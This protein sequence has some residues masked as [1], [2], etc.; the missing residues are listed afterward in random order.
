MVFKKFSVG[1]N[2]TGRR[3]DRVLKKF[4]PTLPL[5][6]I[7]QSIRSGFIRLNDKKAKAETLI[8]TDDVISIAEVLC[9][10]KSD[11]QKTNQPKNKI[12]LTDVFINQHIRIINK[13][14]GIAVHDGEKGGLTEI[15]SSD[16]AEKKKDNSLSFI[17]GPLHRLDI[18]TTGLL[19]FSQSIDGA[20]IF[21]EMLQN[22]EIKKTY[23]AILQGKVKDT[24]KLEDK[25]T[26]KNRTVRVAKNDDKAAKTAIT[27]VIPLCHG[28]YCDKDLTLAKIQI[29]TG[30][31]H[32]IRAQCSVRGFPLL[33]DELYGGMK[34][35]EPSV[36][37]KVFLHAWKLEVPNNNKLNVPSVYF[38]SL[39]GDFVLIL[40]KFLPDFDT[41][42]YTI[43]SYE[44]SK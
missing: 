37:Q 23:L 4:L 22:H 41:K 12:K 30:R 19:V 42:P 14:Y 36:Q 16:Y 1:T 3:F 29:E 44:A 13:P 8:S 20:R 2:D 17:P 28:V 11:E 15:I 10:D 21:S 38:A 27:N 18:I 31:T 40:K 25:L 9:N 32:Q 43:N 39:P 34:I 26:E 6:R 33:G 5:S 7:Y 24:L 35:Q